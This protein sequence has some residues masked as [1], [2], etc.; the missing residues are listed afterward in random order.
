M[1]SGNLSWI[2]FN[3]ALI[4]AD[5]F[6]CTQISNPSEY[7]VLHLHAFSSESPSRDPTKACV[8]D[9]DASDWVTQYLQGFIEQCPPYWVGSDSRSLIWLFGGSLPF[10]AGIN[11]VLITS[12]SSY[13]WSMSGQVQ[14]KYVHFTRPSMCVSLKSQLLV[15]NCDL[16]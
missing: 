8:I 4:S 7:T 13:R 5:L 12:S 1:S 10:R 3:V 6:T 15:W 16:R 14:H 2:W 11:V 9:V